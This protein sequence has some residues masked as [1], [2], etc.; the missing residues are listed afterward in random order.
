[1]GCPGCDVDERTFQLLLNT[2]LLAGAT[3][4]ISVPL[5]T[6]LAWLLTR[7]DLLGRRLW[8]ALLGLMLFVPLYL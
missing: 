8:L 3:C 1:M 2:L 7:T 6:V 5:G 4:A